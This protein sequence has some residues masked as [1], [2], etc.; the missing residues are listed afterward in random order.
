M[1]HI[2][3]KEIAFT[4]SPEA[5]KLFSDSE[6]EIG[7]HYIIKNFTK[8]KDMLEPY[9]SRWSPSV[10]K[11]SMIMQLLYDIESGTYPGI[12]GV[13]AIYAAVNLIYPAIKSTTALLAGNL[14]SQPKKKKFAS[15][16]NGF[17][18]K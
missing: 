2:D 7:F 16:M 9:A 15:S 5:Q 4:L 3:Q 17:V 6:K 14:V 13:E 18:R 8:G 1:S 11:L 10:L 12:I